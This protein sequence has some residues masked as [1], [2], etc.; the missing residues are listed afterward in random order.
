MTYRGRAQ[1]RDNTVNTVQRIEN[2][3]R[4]HPVLSRIIWTVY[5]FG[6]TSRGCRILCTPRYTRHTPS[7]LETRNSRV[8]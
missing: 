5:V 2:S 3:R 1:P 8:E 6:K 7:V 4:R